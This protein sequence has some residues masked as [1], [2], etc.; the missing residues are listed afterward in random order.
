MKTDCA[1]MATNSCDLVEQVAAI[2][3]YLDD[4]TLERRLHDV[5]DELLPSLYEL[6]R[7]VRERSWKA[8]CLVVAEMMR[9]R[10]YGDR[11]AEAVREALGL[12]S[13]RTVQYRA[14]VGTLLADPE[15]QATE[16]VLNG[17]TWFRIA[18]D[19]PDP[20]AAIIHAADRKAADPGYSTR[21]FAA[22]VRGETPLSV[23]LI[24][25]VAT[26]SDSDQRLAERLHRTYNVPVEVRED[27]A[28]PAVAAYR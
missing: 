20:K 18:S 7:S 11:R 19:A 25:L 13:V 26:L 16:P 27:V 28:G 15:I 1:V 4:E 24:V 14:A 5:P 10:R 17:E 22:E 8:Q 6:F 9:R 23:T 3:V 2:D 12:G 21:Q